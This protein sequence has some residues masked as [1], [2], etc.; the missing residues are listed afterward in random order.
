MLGLHK[1][2]VVL[3]I[4]MA[5]LKMKKIIKEYHLSDMKML[6]LLIKVVI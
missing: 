1:T 3:T 5:Q 2:K 6:E 4:Y